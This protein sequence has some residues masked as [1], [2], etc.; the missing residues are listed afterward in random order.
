M[1]T[2]TAFAVFMFGLILTGFGVG[3]IENSIEDRDL[4]SSLAVA[5]VGLMIMFAGTAGI[6]AA[7]YYDKTIDNP[8]LR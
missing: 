6:Q 3:G 1:K 7:S 4:L 2:R 5:V 8:T